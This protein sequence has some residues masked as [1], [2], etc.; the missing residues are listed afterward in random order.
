M[1]VAAALVFGPAGQAAFPG[2]NG[3]IAFVKT[4]NGND[5]IYVMGADGSAPQN[6]TNNPATDT[7]PAWRADGDELLFTS[8]RSGGERIWKLPAAGGTAHLVTLLPGT[9]QE[10]SPAWGPDG[11]ITWETTING[12]YEIYA[13]GADDQPK[14]LTANDPISDRAPAWSPDGTKIAFWSTRNAGTGRDIY[15]MNA[16]GSGVQQLTTYPESDRDPVWSPDGKQ[17]AFERTT[18]DKG[19]EI[20]V[21]NATGTNQQDITNADGNDRNAAWSP[22]GKQIAFR[23]SRDGPQDI[24]V[25]NADGSN[26]RRL[27][28]D[29]ALDD[30]PDW[31]PMSEDQDF[32]GLLDEW[33]TNG[34][35]ANGDGKVDVPLQKMGAD[36]RHK[37]IFIEVDKMVG[38]PFYSEAAARVVA[39]FASAPVVNPDGKPGVTMHIDNGSGT[40][41]NP[42]TGARWGELSQSNPLPHDDVLG[43]Y[44]GDDYVWD[45]FDALKAKN[46]AQAR[47][48]IFHYA[49][50]AHRYGSAAE[51]SSGISRGFGA[52]DLIV[53]LADFCPGNLECAGTS[54]EQAGTFMHELGHNLD[55]R[56][57]GDE[58]TNYKPNYLSIM[59]YRFQFPGLTRN[60]GSGILDYSRFSPSGTGG[61]TNT[62]APLD[63]NALDETTGFAVFGSIVSG[64]STVYT[65]KVWNG[66]RF[67]DNGSRSTIAVPGRGVDWNCNG[68]VDAGKVQV[69]LND[70]GQLTKL[71]SFNDWEHLVYE[72]G[73]IGAGGAARALA[74]RTPGGD[75]P[76]AALIRSARLVRGDRK[77]PT[78][79]VSAPIR[80]RNGTL[81]IPIVVRDDKALGL[82][83]LTID[84]TSYQLAA[85]KGQKLIR[86]TGVVRKPG[87]R[88]VRIAA[89]DAVGNRSKLVRFRVVVRR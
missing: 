57:G 68:H 24:Y 8:Q 1:L 66:T 9:P 74:R 65:C 5:E 67:V 35:D 62:I 20:F 38:H 21:M 29:A 72:G 86:A 46:F 33:E 45:A 51:G 28:N 82:L 25:M 19:T 10:S 12:G 50:F 48:R 83:V 76:V 13:Q 34:Y 32:D 40:V 2:K 87:R 41:M 44:A 59:S 16:D 42:K 15:V 53:S 49:V 75:A 81:N 85:K 11:R 7:Q 22:D 73:S 63:E 23:S 77:A 56:H 36:P 3:K 88:L 78:L 84:K 71:S 37:D 26:V 69:D 6:L 39:A 79:K 30:D 58:H 18:P 55:L 64:S 17:I 70:D 31:Q 27:T 43:T 80:Q 60:D 52:S 89:T 14:R 61:A 47:R 54:D 4:V